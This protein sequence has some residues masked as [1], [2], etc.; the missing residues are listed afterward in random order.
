MLV[1]VS[2]IHIDDGSL[3]AELLSHSMARYFRYNTSRILQEKKLFERPKPLELCFLGDCIDVLRSDIWFED[4]SG[5]KPWSAPSKDQEN[6][7]LR[8][9]KKIIEVN[10]E[11]FQ[12]FKALLSGYES[13]LIYVI[14]NHDHLVGTY[15]SVQDLIMKAFG[16][17]ES[18]V[19][20]CMEYT[21]PE[22][23]VYAYHGHKYDPRNYDIPSPSLGS[24]SYV[25]LLNRIPYE[26]SK[27][28]EKDSL[29]LRR[30]KEF[31]SVELSNVGLWVDDILSA[32]GG[33]RLLKKSFKIAVK[34]FF[35]LKIVD[36]WGWKRM[37][38]FQW[39]GILIFKISLLILAYTPMW[40]GRLLAYFATYLVEGDSASEI[41]L[42]KAYE[43]LDRHTN[44]R[45]RYVVCGHT[46]A[47]RRIPLGNHNG[48]ENY[49]INAGTW[50]RAYERTL[51]RRGKR[52][53]LPRESLVF[54]KQ[55]E[56]SEFAFEAWNGSLGSMDTV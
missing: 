40:V 37:P 32:L 42:D 9:V 28:I 52:R 7:L 30:A 8:I 39:I 43:E 19:E 5:V 53:F 1:V 54:Y 35:S 22:Y 41:L 18:R 49:Y 48:V 50:G 16:L 44:K 55:D 2:D 13:R 38:F 27:L 31:T 14:G 45:I 24:I 34:R 10:Y 56:K 29:A 51:S 23:G 17:D 11:V 21:W 26:L 6:L 33:D 3:S 46:H 15:K 25:E 12:E 20:F 47:F 36:T 4:E